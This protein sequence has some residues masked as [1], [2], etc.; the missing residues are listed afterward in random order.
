MDI[1]DTVASILAHK[2]VTDVW[3]VGATS[4]VFAAIQSMSDNNIGALPV[5]MGD[6][7]LGIVSERD[8]TR[9]VILKG[10]SSKETPVSDIMTTDV[11]T[12]SPSV[13]VVACLQLMSEKKI[14]HLPVLEDGKLVGMISIGDL[15]RRIISAQG[16]LIDQLKD[17]VIGSY[18]E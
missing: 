13:Q 5:V 14:R 3:T 1:A 9:N 8:Y 18:P 15:V 12:V 10:R 11:I 2:S 17:Y 4:T 7:L 16:A 6:Q